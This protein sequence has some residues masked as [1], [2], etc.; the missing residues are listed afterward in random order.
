MR[1]LFG[2]N[3]SNHTKKIIQIQLLLIAVRESPNWKIFCC[4]QHDVAIYFLADPGKTPSQRALNENSNGALSSKRWD[5]TKE[6]DFNEVDSG[7]SYRLLHTKRNIIP[8]K[9]IKL[10]GVPLSRALV[11]RLCEWHGDGFC[12]FIA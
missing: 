12:V 2:I 6:W 7:F 9:V 5:A 3:G 11:S 4:N 8:K 10:A 1:V